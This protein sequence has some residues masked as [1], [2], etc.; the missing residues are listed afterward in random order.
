MPSRS[1]MPTNT[2]V[3][4]TNGTNTSATTK[5]G[6]TDTE[7]TWTPFTIDH[8]IIWCLRWTRRRPMVFCWLKTNGEN[9][10][11]TIQRTGVH[12]PNVGCVVGKGALSLDNG[13]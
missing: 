4:P 10:T 2:T 12:G 13:I 6:T 7:N 9:T 5:P 8:G 1:I 11:G 3:L